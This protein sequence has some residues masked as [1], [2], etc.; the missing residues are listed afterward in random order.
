VPAI[1]EKQT[2]FKEFVT[3]NKILIHSIANSNTIKNEDGKTVVP[4]NDPWR[5][6]NEWDTYRRDRK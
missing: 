5:N 2:S 1:V 3:K 6:E 4:K